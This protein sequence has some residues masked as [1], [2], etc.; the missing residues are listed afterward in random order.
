MWAILCSLSLYRIK[1]LKL[2]KTATN[3]HEGIKISRSCKQQLPAQ[4]KEQYYLCSAKLWA[5]SRAVSGR[6]TAANL[7]LIV[8]LP[9]MNP[10]PAPTQSYPPLALPLV[11]LGWSIGGV[12]LLGSA[13]EG[14]EQKGLKRVD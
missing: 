4:G 2:T 5:L 1:D 12:G 8:P 3:K 14:Q 10:P 11:C 6:R 9:R 13:T 7:F